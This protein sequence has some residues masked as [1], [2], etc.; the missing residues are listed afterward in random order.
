M[1]QQFAEMFS[2]ES[3]FVL[4]LTFVSGQRH[5]TAVKC[6]VCEICFCIFTAYSVTKSFCLQS[7]ACIIIIHVSEEYICPTSKTLWP[8]SYYLIHT[9]THTHTYHCILCV[10]M[11]PV[12]FQLK[13]SLIFSHNKQK[14]MCR[15]KSPPWPSSVCVLWELAVKWI[16]KKHSDFKWAK[17]ILHI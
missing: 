1:T 14:N 10:V 9:H 2:P 12:S 17:C 4:H 6:Q 8:G 5:S 11:R 16:Y 13:Y 7:V 3:W 15:N